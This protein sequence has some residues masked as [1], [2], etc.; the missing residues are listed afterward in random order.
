M[1]DTWLHRLSHPLKRLL[2]RSVWR[3]LRGFATGVLMPFRFAW[4]TGHLRSSLR[5]TAVDRFGRALPWYSYPAIQFLQARDFHGKTVLEFG[6]GNSTLWWGSTG[7]EVISLEGDAGWFRELAIK[8]PR[9][10]RLELVSVESR[11]AC[12]E[13]VR[14]LL[15]DIGVRFDI[16][17]VDGLYREQV[18][19]I[20]LDWVKEDGLI[21]ADDSESYSLFEILKGHGFSRVDFYGQAPGVI[22]PRCTSIWFADGCW[23]FDS[24]WPIRRIYKA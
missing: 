9:N 24:E 13:A 16:V 15:E 21:I 6:A 3:G 4:Q 20:A 22:L 19:A 1:D 18:A 12:T 8:L 7:A 2:P 10:V 23:L 17:I 14:S 11:S 5:G